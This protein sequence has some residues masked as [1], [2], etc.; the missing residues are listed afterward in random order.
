MTRLEHIIRP[1]MNYQHFA[2]WD[3]IILIPFSL[4]GFLHSTLFLP[5]S[6]LHQLSSQ[7]SIP[8]PIP[9]R[10]AHFRAMFPPFT[11]PDTLSMTHIACLS[12]S[13]SNVTAAL[14]R[15]RNRAA[16]TSDPSFSSLE[17]QRTRSESLSMEGRNADLKKGGWRDLDI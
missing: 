3:D 6:T 11:P 7:K 16:S 8:Y 13:L 9:P 10:V 2:F 5:A 14:F 1:I 17:L 15:R 12:Q 4:T